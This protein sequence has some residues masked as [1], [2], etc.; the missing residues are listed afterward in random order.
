MKIEKLKEYYNR[1]NE[2]SVA[3]QE[4]IDFEYIHNQ[5][6]KVALYT[7]NLNQIIGEVLVDQTR[8]EHKITNEKF[9][10]ELKFTQYM[11][12]NSEVKKLSTAKERKDYINYFLMKDVYR[13]ILDLEQEAKDI[14]NLL[15]LARKKSRDLDRTYPKLKILWESLSSEVKNIK[16]IGSD[17]DHIDRVRNK[18]TDGA[19]HSKPVFSD[20]IVEEI[21][22]NQYDIEE[23]SNDIPDISAKS[24]EDLKIEQDVD[25][26]LKDL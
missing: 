25:D 1:I 22:T 12:N 16:K 5:I 10:Y 17:M 11:I 18:I 2:C 20:N 6:T 15:E 13:N 23:E 26:L 14:S 24:E 19:T 7:E 4:D 3:L 9:E 21:S 8:L